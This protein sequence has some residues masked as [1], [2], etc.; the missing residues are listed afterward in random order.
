MEDLQGQ[1]PDTA[2]FLM[3]THLFP[4]TAATPDHSALRRAPEVDLQDYIYREPVQEDAFCSYKMMAY[5]RLVLQ[6]D[7]FEVTQ[8]YGDTVRVPSDVCKIMEVK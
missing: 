6:T 8:S 2:V 1:H 7:I 3:E 5:P 4:A